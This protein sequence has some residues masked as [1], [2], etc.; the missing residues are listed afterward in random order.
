MAT[1]VFAQSIAVE[2]ASQA[3][4]AGMVRTAATATAAMRSFMRFSR[5]DVYEGGRGRTWAVMAGMGG[6]TADLPCARCP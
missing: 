3:E 6:R 2:M 4:R 5:E 1:A